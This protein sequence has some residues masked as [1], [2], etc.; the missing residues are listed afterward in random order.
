M[1]F[2]FSVFMLC[3]IGAAPMSSAQ[4]S[5]TDT[6]VSE[7]PSAS[8]QVS[9]GNKAATRF[10]RMGSVTNAP[11]YNFGQMQGIAQYVLEHVR[12][13][14]I[15]R[16]DVFTIGSTEDMLKLMQA[17]KVDWVS[18]TPY[19]AL[20][21][22]RD[23]NAEF[24]AT[25]KTRGRANYHS[26]FFTRKDSG[27]NTLEDLQGKVIAFE[28]PGSTSAFFLPAMALLDAGLTLEEL[29]SP[30]DVPAEN[31]IGYVFSGDEANSSTWVHK[32]ISVAAAFSN[33]DWD[34]KW[35]TPEAYRDDLLIFHTTPQVP[36]S[37]EVV[38]SELDPL[39]KKRIKTALFATNG[40]PDLT[41]MLRGYYGA[42]DFAELTEAQLEA[43]ER[44]RRNMGK[45]HQ[46]APVRSVTQV[47]QE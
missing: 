27:I 13:L 21:Y 33:A 3:L 6:S 16:V 31:S 35:M 4:T 15:E 25:R 39:L 17:G 41:D 18:A 11:K 8:S 10:L 42:S 14:G 36:R 40:N 43:L 29:S 38:R 47:K 30:R 45:F 24:L 19:A 37:I 22:E 20:M 46:A 1:R 28:K 9:Y 32:R 26:V 23:A 2:L 5:I 44:I 34:S 12:D 7:P